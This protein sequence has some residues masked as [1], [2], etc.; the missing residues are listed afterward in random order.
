MDGGWTG[1]RQFRLT[2]GGGG[3]W[4]TAAAEG[5]EASCS[6][7]VLGTV[8]KMGVDDDHPDAPLLERILFFNNSVRTRSPLFRASPGPPITS[9]NNAVEFTGCGTTG[10]RRCR[11]APESEPSCGGTDVWTKDHLA[12]F[13]ECFPLTDRDNRPIPHVMRFNAYNRPPGPQLDAIDQDGVVAASNF[14]HPPTHD[15]VTVA[16]SLTLKQNGPL[17]TGGCRV[18]Y[19]DGDLTCAAPD[20]PVGAILPDGARFDLELPFRF[21]FVEVLQ[22]A[23]GSPGVRK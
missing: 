10:A 15:A 13:A 16:K 7:H 9:Y 14:V 1:S 4:S 11:Q 23:H 6:T 3:R 5:E 21:P 18:R 12:V 22:L 17:P 20:G 19:V 8:I 2:L